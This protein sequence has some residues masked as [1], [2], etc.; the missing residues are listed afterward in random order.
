[1]LKILPRTELCSGTGHGVGSSILPP[2]T[3]SAFKPPRCKLIMFYTYIIRCND[4]SFYTGI[5]YNLRKRL[6]EHSLGKVSFTKNKKPLKLVFL[7]SFKTREEAARR[8]KEIKGWRREKK[9][10][11]IKDSLH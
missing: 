2:G 7:K 1:M 9:E 4:D 6:K 5:T 11:L 8:E 3:S 10:N